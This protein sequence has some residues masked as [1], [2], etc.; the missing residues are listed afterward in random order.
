MRCPYC[1]NGDYIPLGKKRSAFQQVAG[2]LAAGALPVT[3]AM[4]MNRQ[5]RDLS[6]I[7][8][9][10]YK[11][12]QCKKKYEFAPLAAAPEEMLESPCTI[13]FQRVKALKGSAEV[14]TVY[15]NGAPICTVSNGGTFSFETNITYNN[16]FVGMGDGIVFHD[17]FRFE[18]TPGAVVNVRFAGT[19]MVR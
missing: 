12:A 16:I 2:G 3:A 5:A 8:P 14:Y 10:Q 9:L 17:L 15:L 19:S 11:C 1:G 4:V 7:K 18:A 6:E 13:N